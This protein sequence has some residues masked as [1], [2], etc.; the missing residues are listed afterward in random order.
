MPI[1][2]STAVCAVL[3]TLPFGQAL[4]YVAPDHAEKMARGL[5]LFKNGVGQ[6][7]K[8]HC[9]KCHGG[10]KTRGDFDLTTREA[11][12]KGGSEGAAIVPGNANASR[13]LKLVSHAEKPFMPA[14]AEKLLPA[15]VENIAAWI[16]T[17]APYDKPLV[18]TKLAA[19]EMQITDTDRQHWAF[20]P[21]AKPATPAVENTQWPENEIDRFILAKLE[22]AKLQPNRRA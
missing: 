11:L 18:D 9:V 3:L 14:K 19:G 20:A 16:N 22:E 6:M 21:L 12:L 4:A 13:L 17:G 10:E 5:K 1:R 8:Q 2:F 15:M 7:L